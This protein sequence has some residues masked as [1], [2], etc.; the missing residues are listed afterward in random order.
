MKDEKIT[1]EDDHYYAYIDASQHTITVNVHEIAAT[2]YGF[3][4]DSDSH[5]M[6]PMSE[7]C[8]VSFVATFC[9]RGVWDNR[10]YFEVDEYYGEDLSNIHNFYYEILEPKCIEIIKGKYPEGYNFN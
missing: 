6:E 5:E 1:V 10:L 9:W 7:D 2:G 4:K 8:E 3:K